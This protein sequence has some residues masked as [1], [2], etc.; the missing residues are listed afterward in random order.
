MQHEM[1]TRALGEPVLEIEDFCVEYGQGRS[2]VRAVC[3]ANLTLHRGEMLGLAGESGAGKSTLAYGATRL[4]RAPGVT[5]RGRVIFHHRGSSAP[6][7]PS[8]PVDLLRVD[9]S[10]SAPVPWSSQPAVVLQSAVA[11]LNPMARIGSQ[12]DDVLRLHRPYLFPDERRERAAEM[13]RLVGVSEDRRLF[14]PHE[15]PGPVRQRVTIALALILE[16]QVVIMDEPT[17]ALDVLTQREILEELAALRARLGFA[18]VFITHDFSPLLELTDSIAIMYAGRIVE[19]AAA[20]D[21]FRA[22]RHPYSHRLLNSYLALNGDRLRAGGAGPAARPRTA[23]TGCAFRPRCPHA[24]ERCRTGRPPLEPPAG[25]DRDRAVAC[26]LHD[27]AESIP[28]SLARPEPHP[29]G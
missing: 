4:L 11:S 17:T 6:S 26:W 24:M 25:S 27:G 20:Q 9:M 19:Y 21:L 18:V 29:A 12:F 15:L 1:D 5:T 28:E 10:R 23:L 16:P 3:D 2:A 22:P 14:Y 7:A 13:L 8:R